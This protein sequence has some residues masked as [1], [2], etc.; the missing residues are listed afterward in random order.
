MLCNEY[1]VEYLH[2]CQLRVWVNRHYRSFE[3]DFHI[4]FILVVVIIEYLILK[5]KHIAEVTRYAC[6]YQS[7]IGDV[8]KFL[9]GLL[10]GVTV[11]ILIVDDVFTTG[12]T[13]GACI[14]ML[15]EFFDVNVRISCAT[16]GYVTSG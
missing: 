2:K 11:Y 16:L 5:R 9:F 12:A 4:F 1:D 3:T 8:S 14:C 10:Y 15:Q 7:I 13:M 6:I